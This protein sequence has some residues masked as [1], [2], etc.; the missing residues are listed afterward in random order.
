M[1]H[2]MV[3][4]ISGVGLS[5]ALNFGAFAQQSPALS[6]ADYMKQ[7]LAAGPEAVTKGGAVV[8]PEH[9]G[10]MRTLRQGTNGFTC[11]I[12]GTDRMCADKNSMEFIH[13]MMSH[14]P[15]S[16]QIGIAYML[17]GDTGPSG[18]A[19]GASN[20]DP[21]A[22]AKTADNHWVVTGPHIMIF[23]PPAKALGYTE[24]ADPDP[25]K[26]YM[27]WANTPYEHAMVPV[28]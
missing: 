22:T 11:L 6:D 1:F 26:P 16:N 20:V 19:G 4:A 8:R 7:A 5:I 17:G 9:D 21:S 18:E 2:R 23:G 28:K 13:A 15:P 25:T 27:M 24:V 14:Q 10:T 3:F 12:M